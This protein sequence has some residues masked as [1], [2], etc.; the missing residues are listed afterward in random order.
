MNRMVRLFGTSIGRKLVVATTGI[1][2]LGFIVVHMIGNMTIFRSAEALNTYADWLQGHPLLWIARLG[3]LAVFLLHVGTVASLIVETRRARSTAYDR[4]KHVAAKS[5]SRY[6]ALS[7]MLVLAFIMFHIGHL[8]LGMFQGESFEALD[9]A[10][11]HDVFRIVVNGF[12]N[13]AISGFY[14]AAM[15]AI[16]FHLAHGIESAVQ[17]LGFK[18]DS[19]D[20]LISIGGKTIVAAIV[21]GNCAFPALVLFGVIGGT[22]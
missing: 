13:P 19:Y 2:L 6:M 17:S 21:L 1:A 8:T 22:D 14:V 18:H 3:L 5:S 12:Q 7:G 10:G 16:G 20:T 4:V 15:I 9:A 11:R